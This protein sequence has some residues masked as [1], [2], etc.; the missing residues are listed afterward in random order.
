MPLS[1]ITMVRLRGL[2][3]PMVVRQPSAIRIEPSPSI[4]ITPRSGWASANHR[5]SFVVERRASNTLQSTCDEAS[6]RAPAP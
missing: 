5:Q 3:M 4:A 6:R 1:M 2:T